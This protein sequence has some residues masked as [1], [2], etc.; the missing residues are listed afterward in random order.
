VDADQQVR[1]PRLAQGL[2][3]RPVRQGQRVG[4]ERRRQPDGPAVGHQFE[5]L[6]VDGRFAALDVHGRVAVVLAQARTDGLGLVQGHE[7]M[8][9]VVDVLDAVL[10]IAE[11]AAQ[12]AGLAE[13]EHAAFGDGQAATAHADCSR[14][15]LIRSR[16][17]FSPS[18]LSMYQL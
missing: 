11:M 2:A 8:V 14:R 15:G 9:R 17:S 3:S 18:T 12:I 6:R 4:D 5:D 13:P 10:K 7:R 16:Y 1:H